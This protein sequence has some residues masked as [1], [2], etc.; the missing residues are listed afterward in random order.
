MNLRRIEIGTGTPMIKVVTLNMLFGPESWD[1]RRE[2]MAEGLL[3]EQPDCLLLQE[4]WEHAGNWLAERLMLT[5]KYWIPYQRPSNRQ[6]LQDGIAIF[7]RYPFLQQEMLVLSPGEEQGRVAQRVHIAPNGQPL[8]LCNGHYYWHP[9]PHPVRDQQVERIIDWLGQLPEE[10]PIVVGGDFNGTPETSAIAL[11]RQHYTSAYAAHNG[12]EPLFTCPT[13]LSFDWRNSW[14]GT[15]DYLF[16]TASL[17]IRS[18]RLILY[19]P[20]RHN[21]HIYPSDHFGL[22]AELD[23]R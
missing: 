13:P 18:C 16:V 5:H 11:M 15:V 9:G 14:R 1:E 6:G 3:A 17:R 20:S 12:A 4:V 2:L 23:P 8:V 19:W 7:S 22:V 21:P 10:L